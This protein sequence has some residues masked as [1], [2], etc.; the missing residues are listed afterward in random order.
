[1]K[2]FIKSYLIAFALITA[3]IMNGCD[4]FEN[5][6]FGLP[7]SFTINTSGSTNPSGNETFCL[8]DDETYQDYSD[9]L[10]SIVYVES[11]MVTLDAN[12]TA[13]TGNGVLRIYAGTSSAGTL[14]FEHTANNITPADYITPNPA[15]KIELTEAQITSINESLASGNTCFYGEY[16]VAVTSGGGVTNSVDVRIDILYNIDTSL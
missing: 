9:K 14:L 12:P 3:V 6:L 10:N 5:F 13:L 1:M 11:Y 2:K 15:Y 7:I 8:Q 16:S 4:A